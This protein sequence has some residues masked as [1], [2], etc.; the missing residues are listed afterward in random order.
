MLLTNE[1]RTV[2]ESTGKEQDLARLI[3]A[4]GGSLCFGTNPDFIELVRNRKGN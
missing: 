2:V 3:L 4:I 1:M